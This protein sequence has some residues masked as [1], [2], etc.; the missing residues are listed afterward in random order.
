MKAPSERSEEVALLNW[1]TYHGVVLVKIPNEGKR[2]AQYCA[3]LKKQ[4]LRAGFPD[5]FAVTKFSGFRGG[6]IE[7][8]QNRPYTP[9]EKAKTSWQN[10]EWWINYLNEQGYLAFFSYGWIMG[11]TILHE[12]Y[13]HHPTEERLRT[14]IKDL[15]PK[16]S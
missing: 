16:G 12:A 11:A 9:S 1:A 7:M 6:F 3:M 14:L 2:S 4:G 10:Q 15:S 13:F 8:K 5:L